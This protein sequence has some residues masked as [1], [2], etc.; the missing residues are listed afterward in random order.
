MC[1][2]VLHMSSFAFDCDLDLAH[3]PVPSCAPQSPGVTD[4][5]IQHIKYLAEG[6]SLC[7]L[8]F[9]AVQHQLVQHHWAVHG[10]GQTVAF[11]DGFNHLKEGQKWRFYMVPNRLDPKVSFQ[12]QRVKILSRNNN[13]DMIKCIQK[14]ASIKVLL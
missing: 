5:F 2:K 3:V 9:P 7:T 10:G 14:Q 8:S 6:G 4:K 11:F 12:N 1:L 13:R